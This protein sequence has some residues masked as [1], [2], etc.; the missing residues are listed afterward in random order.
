MS[1]RVPSQP[2]NYNG[3]ST[4]VTNRGQFG[5]ASSPASDV[6][7]DHDHLPMVNDPSDIPSANLL[8]RQ[9]DRVMQQLESAS[10]V[11]P[12]ARSPSPF[13]LSL[14]APLQAMLE[15]EAGRHAMSVKQLCD[16][17]FEGDNI[18]HNSVMLPDYVVFRM[19]LD[20]RQ[21]LLMA[22]CEDGSLRDVRQASGADALLPDFPDLLRTCKHQQMCGLEIKLAMSGEIGN[23]QGLYNP[24]EGT[25]HINGE[26]AN[27][28]REG[29]ERSLYILLVLAHE[30]EHAKNSPGLTFHDAPSYVRA[31]EYEEGKAMM[32][33]LDFALQVPPYL[34]AEFASVISQ[35]LPPACVRIHEDFQLQKR[36]DENPARLET[37]ARLELGAI[38]SSQ[39]PD[40]SRPAVTMKD[41]WQEEYANL[42]PGSSP[43]ST[44]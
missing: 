17:A 8:T 42:P 41:V 3:F 37:R 4:A 1:G 22:K 11:T 2:A 12:P 39:V 19:P 9:R 21:T 23:L 15:T 18:L 28:F 13:S 25:I 20:G 43:G 5:D 34:A 16:H 6:D 32:A 40:P 27:N 29:N 24:D 7:L 38:Y 44:P 36:W 14:G 35:S 33:E 10:T 26:L 31:K 30:L